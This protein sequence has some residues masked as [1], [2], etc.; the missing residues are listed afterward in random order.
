PSSSLAM[1]DARP[2]GESRAAWD[3]ALGL[4]DKPGLFDSYSVKGSQFNTPLLEFSAAC[5]GCGETPYAK[6]LTQLFGERVYWANATGCSQAWGSPFPGIPY[7]T[8]KRG[9]GPAWTNSLFENNAELAYGMLLSVQQQR[10]AEKMRVKQLAKSL[11]CGMAKLHGDRGD[12]PDPACMQEL[13]GVCEDYLAAFDSFEDS[14]STAD[15]LVEAV[16]RLTPHLT[17]SAA[18]FGAEVV[19]YKDQLAKKTFWMFGGDGWAY[20][21]GFGGL[22]H[23]IASGENLNVLVVDTEVYSN[24]GGQSSKATP[25][26]AVAQFAASG[27]KTR[28]KDLGAIL[29]SYGNVYVAQVAMGADYNQLIKALKEAESYDGPAVVIAY[30]PCVTHGL[31]CGMHDVQGEM[32]RAVEAGYWHLYRYDPRKDQPMQL[33]SK[34]PNASFQE[35]LEGEVRYASLKRSFPEEAE[36]LFELSAEDAQRRYEKYRALA[37]G[38]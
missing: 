3:Y 16:E 36:R 22:D 17:R 5:A 14:R 26:G 18:R 9:F 4:S 38:E 19:R 20:D 11:K 31:K 25:V 34:E 1:E 29:M 33:D 28:K 21:I 12:N 23:V 2:N 27:K 35:F 6:L 8:S 7:T 37:D 32:R 24:T 13:L 30:A 10:E 15:A